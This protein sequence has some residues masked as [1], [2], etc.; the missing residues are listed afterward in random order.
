MRPVPIFVHFPALKTSKVIVFPAFA[1]PV[2][3]TICTALFVK[4]TRVA[5]HER[6]CAGAV[7]WVVVVAATRLKHEESVKDEE[8]AELY[9]LI[10][11]Q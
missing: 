5:S 10:E 2:S 7:D 11:K 4:L 3:T 1:I 9:E 6:D 8:P